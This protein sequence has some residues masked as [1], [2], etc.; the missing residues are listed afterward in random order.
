MY[1]NEMYIAISDIVTMRLAVCT[2]EMREKAP[3]R[4]D[5]WPLLKEAGGNW[6]SCGVPASLGIRVGSRESLQ[7]TE[8]E[9]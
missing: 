2:G 3:S 1:F 9:R 7:E 4:T 5:F 6:N 8:R